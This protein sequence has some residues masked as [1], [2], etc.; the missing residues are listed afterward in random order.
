[1]AMYSE[2]DVYWAQEFLAWA[3]KGKGKGKRKPIERTRF[4]EADDGDDDEQN[5]YVDQGFQD[6]EA[7]YG[8]QD[9]QPSEK[10]SST[11]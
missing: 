7:M 8:M 2:D 3:A 4:A 6:L 10:L 9:A 5:H 1:M 11:E